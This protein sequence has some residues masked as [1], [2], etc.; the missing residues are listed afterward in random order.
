MQLRKIAVERPRVAALDIHPV[1]PAK[2]DRPKPIPLRLIKVLAD[3]YLVCELGEHRFNWRLHGQP[4]WSSEVRSCCSYP[5]SVSAETS[6]YGFTED[7]YHGHTKH[8]QDRN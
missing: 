2:D 6:P 8:R 5:Q 4:L 7:R 1:L 3:G